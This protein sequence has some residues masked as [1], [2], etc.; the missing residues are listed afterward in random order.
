MNYSIIR[1]L[2]T[3]NVKLK[4]NDNIYEQIQDF[5]NEETSAPWSS[6][7]TMPAHICDPDRM[8]QQ[9]TEACQAL[10]DALLIDT[11]NDHNTK[12]TAR[13]MA[14]MY[15]TEV[16]KGRYTSRPKITAFD[17][18]RNID[19]VF[20]VGPTTIRSA[21]SHH[22]VPIMGHVWFGVLPDKDGKVLGLSKFMRL[23]DWVFSRPQIQEEATAQLAD[24]VEEELKP[25]GLAIVVRANHL[26]TTWRGVQDKDVAMVTSD[27]RGAFNENATT[28]AEFFSLIKGLGY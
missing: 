18:V 24:I 28:R 12:D 5:L 1:A 4:A 16:F 7:I 21:C 22:M 25:R 2:R 13:R 10:L 20:V 6:D 27:L 19:Q 17:N 9:V 14:K 3:R 23:A 15:I 8:I 11:C 26:C